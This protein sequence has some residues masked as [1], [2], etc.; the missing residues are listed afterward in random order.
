MLPDVPTWK[1]QGVDVLISTA[2]TVIA[3]KGTPREVLDTLY[4]AFKK[5]VNDPEY[6]K[7]MESKGSNVHDLGPD[8]ARN[9]LK[10]QDASFLA[11]IRKSGLEKK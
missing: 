8:E 2:R 9:F 5:A 4:A 10:D 7:T 3:P 6:R 1:E 11:L